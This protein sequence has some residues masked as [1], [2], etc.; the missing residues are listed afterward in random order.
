MSYFLGFV[1]NEESIRRIKGALSEVTPLFDDL[2]IP[3]RWVKP[4]TF[5]ITL[6]Y[7]GEYLNPI[8]QYLLKRKL[9][10]MSFKKI[11]VSLSSIKVGIS[12]NYKELVY[13]DIKEGGEELRELLLNVRKNI[14]DS[15]SS[16]FVP[17]L[18]IGRI[19]KDLSKEEYR[20][21]AKDVSRVSEKL[22]LSDIVFTLD[23]IYLIESKEGIYSFK[24]KF[25]AL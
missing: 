23:S 17:H 6:Y 2:G 25:D 9:S 16:M 20:N 19:S 24:M 10:K 3:V 12:R 1:P 7:L 18:T 8:S 13:I 5:H 15:D 4:N 21:V 14:G 11:H 22:E